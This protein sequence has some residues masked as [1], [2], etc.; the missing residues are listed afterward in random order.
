MSLMQLL[1][2]GKSIRTIEDR[3]TPYKMKQQNLLPK[4]GQLLRE[5]KSKKTGLL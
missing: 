3:P 4:F 2:M 5:S 1:A